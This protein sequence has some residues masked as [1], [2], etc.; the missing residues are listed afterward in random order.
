MERGM[1]WWKEGKLLSKK[2]SFDDYIAVAKYLI[3]K[4]YLKVEN[5]WNGWFSR[6]VISGCSYK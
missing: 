5:N 1:K 3:K 2:N 6:W 4:I